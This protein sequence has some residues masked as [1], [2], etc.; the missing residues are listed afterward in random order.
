[1]STGRISNLYREI[2]LCVDSVESRARRGKNFRK[3][4]VALCITERKCFVKRS[5]ESSTKPGYLCLS[6]SVHIS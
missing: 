2:L 6:T 5:L 4:P 3:A 1:V